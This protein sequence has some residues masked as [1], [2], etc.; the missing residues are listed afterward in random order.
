MLYFWNQ[1]F[2]QNVLE[3]KINQSKTSTSA[4]FIAFFFTIGGI[5]AHRFS[6]QSFFRLG[7]TDQTYMNIV[8][9]HIVLFY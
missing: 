2:V 6:I 4:P 3:N 8:L 5:V 1:I 9:V 7:A